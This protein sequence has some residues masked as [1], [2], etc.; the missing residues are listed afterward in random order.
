MM[1][2]AYL[3]SQCTKFYAAAW[4]FWY[5]RPFILSRI[6]ALMRFRYGSNKRTA[7]D[8]VQTSED[9][10]P[11]PW[12]WLDKRSGKKTWAVNGKYKLTETCE[13]E[14]QEHGHHF[15]WYQGDCSQRIRPGSQKSYFRILL[16]RLTAR[17][18]DNLRRLR[19]ELW[20]QRTRCCIKTMHRLTIPLSAGNS[21]PKSTWL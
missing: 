13:E 3:R 1:V 12:Q 21:L 6:F 4:M 9:V 11:R 18:R 7:S 5:L 10:P 8:F 17:L 19:P 2:L 20:W 14:S 15:I 16:W